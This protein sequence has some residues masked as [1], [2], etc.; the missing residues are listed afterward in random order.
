M[1]YVHLLVNRLQESIL[2]IVQYDYLKSC[3]KDFV[4]Q[5]L[6]LRTKLCGKGVIT[7]PIWLFHFHPTKMVW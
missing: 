2:L 5:D 6:I 3:S 1:M 7:Q 4:L